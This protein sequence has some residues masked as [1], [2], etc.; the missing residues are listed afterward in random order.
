MIAEELINHMIPPLKPSDTSR[1]AKV[2]ME[3]LHC[4]ELPVVSEGKFIGMVSEDDILETNDLQKTVGEYELELLQCFVGSHQHFYDVIKVASNHESELVGVVDEN[5]KY[6]GVITIQ[7]TISSFAQTAAVQV[8]GG[9]IVISM[10]SRDYSLT[11]IS[12]LIE[13]N[14]AKI[15]SSS[16]KDELNEPGR[17]KLTLKINQTDLSHIVS[18][19]E[20]FGYKITARFQEHSTAESS[21]ERIDILLKYLEI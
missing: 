6:L 3:E 18:T 16:I 5:D 21:K 7:D 4:K 20:R 15:L 2:W 8:P 10:D 1:H 9:I 17:I 11:E 14:N 12:R 19:L 13:S